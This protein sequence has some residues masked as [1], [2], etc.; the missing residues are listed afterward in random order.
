MPVNN[1]SR[2]K[3]NKNKRQIDDAL[4]TIKHEM[5]P[6]VKNGKC[7]WKESARFFVYCGRPQVFVFIGQLFFHH[8]HFPQSIRRRM[9]FQLAWTGWVN[10]DD[11]CSMLERNYLLL[12]SQKYEKWKIKKERFYLLPCFQPENIIRNTRVISTCQGPKSHQWFLQ[13]WGFPE[14]VTYARDATS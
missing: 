2:Y 8:I 9:K 1:L 11:T 13:V 3:E 7:R 14:R 5:P 6:N 12:R 10:G 4:E